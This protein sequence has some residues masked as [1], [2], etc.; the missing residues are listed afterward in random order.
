MWENIFYVGTFANFEKKKKKNTNRYN[1]NFIQLLIDWIFNVQTI[2][3]PDEK[4]K[5]K[6]SY[7]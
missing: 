3:L 7:L 4:E 2:D 6:E 1:S 5:E